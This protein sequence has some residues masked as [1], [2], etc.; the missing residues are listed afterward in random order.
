MRAFRFGVT[1]AG[2]PD[3]AAW[4]AMAHRVESLGYNTSSFRTR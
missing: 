3:L 2:P 1:H 4:T